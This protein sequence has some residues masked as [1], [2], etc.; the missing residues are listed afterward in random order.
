[1]ELSDIAVWVIGIAIVVTLY[2]M[3]FNPGVIASR[4]LQKKM[5]SMGTI[6]GKS[7]NEIVKIV[8]TPS[9]TQSALDG[10]L[11]SWNSQKYAINL[12][13]DNNGICTGVFGEKIIK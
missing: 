3:L 13:F 5:I 11:C 8:G 1:M 9:V 12:G 7:Y 4:V 2:K 10:K 6:K